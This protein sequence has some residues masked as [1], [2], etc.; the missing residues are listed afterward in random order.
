M[1]KKEFLEFAEQMKTYL[2]ANKINTI[3]KKRFK[4]MQ[5]MF[6]IATELF[7]DMNIEFQEDPLQLGRII[8]CIKGYGF[9]VSGTERTKMFVELISNADNFEVYSNEEEVISLDIMYGD[10]F[11]VKLIK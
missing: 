9:D 6:E 8:L 3:N 2:E 5:R 1:S 7:P 11:D 10:V 4:D